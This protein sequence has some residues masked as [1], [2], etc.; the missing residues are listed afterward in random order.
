[1]LPSINTQDWGVLSNDWVLVGIGANLNVTGLV[2]LDEPGPS[3]ALDTGES[4]VEL[5][6]EIGEG[7]VRGL[8][9]RLDSGLALHPRPDNPEFVLYFRITHFQLA[10]WLTTTT[11]SLWCQV[12][13]EE[14]VVD[15]ST[16]VEVDDWLKGDLGGNVLLSSSF[17][18]LFGGSVEAVHVGLVVVL[19]VKLHDLARDGRL[20][21]AIV[22]YI[23]VSTHSK[24][25]QG[26]FSLH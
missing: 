8:N 13:P 4:S 2:V 21:G 25:I 14:R 15:V 10:L 19:V 9:S 26:R 6:L 11:L 22:I 16:T 1:M 7:A 12:L 20:E 18:D 23:A 3:T 5:G 24:K 17:L